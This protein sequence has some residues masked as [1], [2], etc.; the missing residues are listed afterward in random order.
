MRAPNHL[1]A[2]R[3]FE[4]AQDLWGDSKTLEPRDGT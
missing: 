2:L 4:S 1:N 3:A